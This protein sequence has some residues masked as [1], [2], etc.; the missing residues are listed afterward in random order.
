MDAVT[1]ADMFVF[2]KT[3]T[4]TTGNFRVCRI[5]TA[6]IYSEAE[7][8]KYIASAE[9]KSSHP[10][11]KA[12]VEYAKQQQ[13]T[14]Y[15]VGAVTEI[16]GYGLEAYIGGKQI[17]AGNYRLMDKYGIA[18]PEGL[19]EMPESLILCACN[20]I[21]AGVVVME[22]E[23]KDDAVEAIRGLKQQGIRH[24]EILSGIRPHWYKTL[25]TVWISGMLMAIYYRP[26]RW[27]AF[28]S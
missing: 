17:L 13:A 15:P 16:A 6:G 12:V 11:A 18:Y 7:V 23:L 4:L 26:I 24:F 3:G 1:K 2:D 9:S 22:D 19:H 5:E 14:L 20:G 21:Y 8:L 25:H 10:M 27:P 28:R